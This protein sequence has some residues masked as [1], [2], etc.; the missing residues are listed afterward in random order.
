MN[1]E[2]YEGVYF[3]EQS[4]YRAYRKAVEEESR[5]P[6]LVRVAYRAWLAAWEARRASRKAIAD[7]LQAPEHEVDRLFHAARHEGATRKRK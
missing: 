2:E 6:T 7:G 1:I 4:A 3:A 5:Y